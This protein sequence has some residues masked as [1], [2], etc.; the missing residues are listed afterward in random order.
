M[1]TEPKPELILA[2]QLAREA[3][4]VTAYVAALD[5][6]ALVVLG[7][8]AERIAT[9]MCNGIERWDPKAG[10]LLASWDEKDEARAERQQ[11]IIAKKAGAILA[12]YAA[13]DVK[14]GGDPRGYCLTFK[15]Q[16]G[17]S[18][19]MSDGVWGVLMFKLQFSTDNAA[20]ADSPEALAY[21]VARILRELADKI[22][23]EP[24]YW[25]EGGS[26]IVRDVNGNN[27][28]AWSLSVSE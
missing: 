2:A 9:Q 22:E 16:S 14:V 24:Q 26:G 10:R 23:A 8:R 18:N 13:G 21:E 28:G 27:V 12:R 6:Q 4:A 25:A 20:F 19:G 1:S 11:E 7:R 3:G 5:A 15:F 17:A